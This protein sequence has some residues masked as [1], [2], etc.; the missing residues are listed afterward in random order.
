[1]YMVYTIEWILTHDEKFRYQ[2]LD[3]MREDCE[4]YLDYGG[5]HPKY[6][7]AQEEREHISYMKQIWQSFSEKPEWLSWDEILEYEK[8][9]CTEKTDA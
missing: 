9:M 7:W 1:M 3:R 4:Y 6:L 8:L 2:L 5:R